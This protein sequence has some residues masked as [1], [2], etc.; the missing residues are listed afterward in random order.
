MLGLFHR[1]HIDHL[2]GDLSVLD[3]PVRAFD[4]AV[5]IDHRVR[6]QAVDQA[7]V[8]AFRGFDRADPAI[9]G[10]VHVANLEAGPLAGQTARAER[11][12][13]SLVGD[14]RQR[15]GLVHELRELR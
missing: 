7:D 11:R 13:A 15:I 14:F 3:P 9:V 1:R 6:G 10:R 4:E 12:Q 5:L 8:R 2:F